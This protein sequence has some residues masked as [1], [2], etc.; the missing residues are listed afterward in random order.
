[1]HKQG[2]LGV[3]I[4]RFE[5]DEL[6]NNLAEALE[7]RVKRLGYLG[8]FFKCCANQPEALRAFIDFSETAKGGLPDNLVEVIALTCAGWVGNEYERNQH[9]R[10]CLKLGF[11]LE[12]ISEVNRCERVATSALTQEEHLVQQAVL[13]ILD[14]RGKAGPEWI[15]RIV[16]RLGEPAVISLLMVIG[17]YVVHGLIVNSLNL[18]PPVNSVFEREER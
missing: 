3:P 1:M 7:P 2:K 10:L 5:F 8:E 15:A 14:T 18:A 9:E 12:W 6:P 11:S 16:D 17:R 13:S 4:R